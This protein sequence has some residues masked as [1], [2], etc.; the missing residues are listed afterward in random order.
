MRGTRATLDPAHWQEALKQPPRMDPNAAE[1]KARITMWTY[2]EKEK[3]CITFMYGGG[4][5]LTANAFATEY[6]CEE[7]ARLAGLPVP[8]TR[9]RPLRLNSQHRWHARYMPI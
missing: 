4:A 6:E 9:L 8:E 3:R 5:A 1:G 2:S 7:K